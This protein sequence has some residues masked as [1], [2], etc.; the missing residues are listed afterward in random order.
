MRTR[1]MGWSFRHSSRITH[2]LEWVFTFEHCICTYVGSNSFRVIPLL[3]IS[4]PCRGNILFQ[5]QGAYEETAHLRG[6]F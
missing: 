6:R 4:S 1:D 2:L 5:V 3:G